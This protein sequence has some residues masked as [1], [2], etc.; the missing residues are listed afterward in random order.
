MLRAILVRITQ[1][2]KCSLTG[3]LIR[4]G[5]GDIDS[6]IRQRRNTFKLLIQPCNTLAQIRLEQSCILFIAAG[7]LVP[8][9]VGFAFTSDPALFI[10]QTGLA[11]IGAVLIKQTAFLDQ[12]F[13]IRS[14]LPVFLCCL[15]TEQR[16]IQKLRIEI[17]TG[18]I[19]PD[20]VQ[21][22]FLLRD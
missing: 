17:L 12:A 16:V 13:Q 18:L 1:E 8:F 5:T 19:C 10:D 7:I 3:T 6:G 14:D 20:P 4:C 2:F 21:F 15:D 22:I 9:L 11:D